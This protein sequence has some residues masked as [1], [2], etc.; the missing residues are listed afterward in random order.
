[1]SS[2]TAIQLASSGA[3]GQ[4]VEHDR[5]QRVITHLPTGLVVTSSEKSQHRNGEIAI[6]GAQGAFI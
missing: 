3:G 1:M 2:H 4:H 5:F 6:A